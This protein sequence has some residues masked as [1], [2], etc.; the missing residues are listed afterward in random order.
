MAIVLRSCGS[1]T[2]KL[3]GCGRSSS[4]WGQPG[5]FSGPVCQT[6]LDRTGFR[7]RGFANTVSRLAAGPRAYARQPLSLERFRS[8]WPSKQQGGAA[9]QFPKAPV[10]FTEEQFVTAG[11]TP[12]QV[13]QALQKQ[14]RQWQ[15]YEKKYTKAYQKQQAAAASQQVV[16]YTVEQLYAAGWTQAQ[17]EDRLRQQEAYQQQLLLQLKQQAAKAGRLWDTWY[18][19]T[20]PDNTIALDPTGRPYLMYNEQYYYYNRSPVYSPTGSPLYDN[21]CEIYDAQ[22]VLQPYEPAPVLQTQRYYTHSQMD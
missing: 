6:V 13:D 9:L 3:P 5:T 21:G 14:F 8:A 16:M 11:Y 7:G 19:A 20:N 12:E 10:L 15:A 18:N 2:L 4:L 17:V 1:A 22:G